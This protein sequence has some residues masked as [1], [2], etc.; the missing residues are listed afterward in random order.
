M[1]RIANVI[2]NMMDVLNQ[3]MQKECTRKTDRPQWG[4]SHATC[5]FSSHGESVD[6]A[7]LHTA[8]IRKKWVKRTSN[9]AKVFRG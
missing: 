8:N 5:E 2:Q 4:Q 1:G 3:Q 6:E 7:V 9:D